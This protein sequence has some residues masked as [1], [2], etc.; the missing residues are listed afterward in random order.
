[1]I[2]LGAHIIT[3]T[4]FPDRTSQVWHVQPEA[5]AEVEK[6]G[7]ADITWEFESEAEFMHLAQ[8]VTLLTM[9]DNSQAGGRLIAKRL[10]MPYLPYARQDKRISNESTFALKTFAFLL[11]SLDFSEVHVLDAHS[12]VWA[13]QIQN[14]VDESPQK[15]IQRAIDESG[16]DLLLFPDASAEKR[17]SAYGFRHQTSKGGLMALDWVTAEKVRTPSTGEIVGFKLG[18]ISNSA[19]RVK[20]ETV[21]GKNVLI[22]DD[23]ADGG[24]TFI[25]AAK[26]AYERGAKTVSL[27][28]THGIFSRGLAPLRE[29]GI[30]KI[31]THKGE[32]KGE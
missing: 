30:K 12:N 29:A 9:Y 21:K 18:E 13:N 20:G 32:V 25:E 2:K 10:S 11:N 17:Y 4:I 15:Y 7:E 5:L 23:L 14:L 24:R 22:V 3:P 16:C 27:Y 6:T 28:V 8:L 31:W 26:A 19:G 1:M